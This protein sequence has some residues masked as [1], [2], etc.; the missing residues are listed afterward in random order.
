MANK[1]QKGRATAQLI[2]PQRLRSLLLHFMESMNCMDAKV[3][4]KDR[5]GETGKQC[6]LPN[7][8]LANTSLGLIV[9]QIL[10]FFFA[11]MHPQTTVWCLG[12]FYLSVASRISCKHRHGK[13]G[14]SQC[15]CCD[16]LF[17][18]WQSSR[19]SHR[20]AATHQYHYPCQPAPSIDIYPLHA[21]TRTKFL[22]GM[23]FGVLQKSSWHL[24]KKCA[25]KDIHTCVNLQVCVFE[26][27]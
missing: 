23:V 24:T 6:L 27:P 26:M 4:F 15:I 7:Q 19:R 14:R 9:S 11:S 18:H 5:V 8:V 20:T 17:W 13:R 3:L 1:N 2:P 25:E 21:Y 12:L 22:L 10:H 16:M